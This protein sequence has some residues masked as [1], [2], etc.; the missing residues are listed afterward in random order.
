MQASRRPFGLQ[1]LSRWPSDPTQQQLHSWAVYHIRRTPAQF[2]GLGYD[3]PDEQSA[4]AKAI[5]EYDVPRNLRNRLPDTAIGRL[6]DQDEAAKLIRRF[7]RGI[8]SRNDRRRHWCGAPP[9]GSGHKGKAPL[10]PARAPSR[11]AGG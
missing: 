5:E 4:I 1:W 6:L 7:E 10:Q 8:R 3:A 9:S 2:V 11:E